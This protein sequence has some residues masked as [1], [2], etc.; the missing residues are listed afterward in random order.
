M[1]ENEEEEKEPID[2]EFTEQKAGLEMM[3]ILLNLDDR[4]CKKKKI[5]FWITSL[6][7]TKASW[8]VFFSKKLLDDCD[9]IPNEK[10]K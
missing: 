6:K 3:K 7:I 2:I 1:K 10:K 5:S 9:I 8:W 4:L